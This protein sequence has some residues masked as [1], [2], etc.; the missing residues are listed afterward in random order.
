[1]NRII[2]NVYLGDYMS[3]L[4]IENLPP[5]EKERWA[6]VSVLRDCPKFHKVKQFIINIDDHSNVNIIKYFEM[7]YGFIQSSLDEG[8]NV[9]IHCAMGISRS[10]TILCAFIMKKYKKNCHD[11]LEII[12]RSRPIVS[13]NMG[14]REQLLKYQTILNHTYSRERI[15]TF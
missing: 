8:K 1:M 11:A 14:F 6:I 15:N 4:S 13:P 7:T 12:K 3:A 2:G 10:T 9:L 5:Y